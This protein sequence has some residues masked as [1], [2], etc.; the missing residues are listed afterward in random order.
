[1]ISLKICKVIINK[2]EAK[3]N[4]VL[5]IFIMNVGFKVLLKKVS[6]NG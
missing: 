3:N 1:M 5:I 4:I 2:V 6:K